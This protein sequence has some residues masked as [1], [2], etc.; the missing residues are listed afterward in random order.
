MCSVALGGDNLLAP[1]C[2]VQPVAASLVLAILARE[3]EKG[4]RCHWHR[5]EQSVAAIVSLP[6]HS[7]RDFR[8]AVFSG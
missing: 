6:F 5:I 1:T 8:D 4:D 7:A 2:I 3:K